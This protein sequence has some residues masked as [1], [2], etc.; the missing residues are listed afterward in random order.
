MARKNRKV[1]A[2]TI[3]LIIVSLLF[4][5]FVVYIAVKIIFKP[6]FI[7]YNGFGIDMP[8]RYDIHGIDVSRYQ[9][10]IDWEAV[11]TMRDDNVGLQFSFIKATEGE[12]RIDPLFRRNWVNAGEEKMAKG[13]YHFFHPSRSGEAQAKNFIRTVTL[14]TG[15]LPPVLDIEKTN[16]QSKE[17]IQEGAATWLKLVEEH[18]GVKPIIYTNVSFYENY[19]AGRFDDYKLWVAHYLQK[20]K[21]R[22]SRE[23]TFWQHSETGRVNGIKATVDFNAFNGDFYDLERL[24]I[25]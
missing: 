15:D 20:N 5:A 1:G 9:G 19:L 14:T 12:T 25:P 10:N 3:L 18:Y 17:R 22:I 7:R 8:S 16:G 23:W 6:E 4:A 11:R 21:P 2:K 24:R 13:A